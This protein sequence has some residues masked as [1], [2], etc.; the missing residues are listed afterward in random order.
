MNRIEQLQAFHKE[1]PEDPSTLYML[2][3][4]YKSID[5]GKSLQLFT[6]LLESN[7]GYLP[8]YY[9]AAGLLLAQNERAKAFLVLDKGIELA[10]RT[11]DQKTKMELVNL[12]GEWE[13]NIE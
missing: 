5:P 1:D 13:E 11:A 7:P 9:Q 10:G 12:K 3:L 2:A 4:E 6:Q 8:A